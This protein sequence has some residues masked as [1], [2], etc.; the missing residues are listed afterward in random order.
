MKEY[1]EV[2]KDKI[3]TDATFYSEKLDATQDY[4][5]SNLELSHKKSLLSS[6]IC[7]HKATEKSHRESTTRPMKRAVFNLLHGSKLVIIPIWKRVKL[8]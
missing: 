1:C 3:S 4:Y 2:N 8:P 6:N 5:A 7:Y